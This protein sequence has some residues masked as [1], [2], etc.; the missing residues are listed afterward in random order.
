MFVPPAFEFPASQSIVGFC[1][2]ARGD[3]CL[4]HDVFD[5]A[6]AIEGTFLFFSAIA[7]DVLCWWW[8]QY[9]SVVGIY[10][11]PD[12][13]DCGVTNL[14]GSS[15]EEFMKG[16]FLRE[17]FVHQAEEG[18]AHIPLDGL[19]ERWIKPSY[20]T[21]AALLLPA[22]CWRFVGHFEVISTCLDGILV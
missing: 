10:Y 18:R 21:L 15:V 12:I 5:Q 6:L 4:I 9:S 17:V 8:V 2:L 1:L 22:H 16:A 20:P 19:G 3:V 13:F 11:C 14:D 7:S